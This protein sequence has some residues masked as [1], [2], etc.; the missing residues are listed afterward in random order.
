MFYYWKQSCIVED[1]KLPSP[2]RGIECN[3]RCPAGTILD[4][5]IEAG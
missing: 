5:D 3:K 4:Y 2:I 1:I